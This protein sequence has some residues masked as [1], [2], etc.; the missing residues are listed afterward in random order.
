MSWL[1]ECIAA[2]GL[3]VAVVIGSAGRLGLL[4]WIWDALEGLK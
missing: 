1:L 2:A 3:F 4:H